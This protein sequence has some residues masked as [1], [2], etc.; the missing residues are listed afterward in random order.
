[1]TCTDAY[2]KE[3]ATVV[4]KVQKLKKKFK[5]FYNNLDRCQLKQTEHEVVHYGKIFN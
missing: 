1:M 3:G 2:W 4:L 5:V